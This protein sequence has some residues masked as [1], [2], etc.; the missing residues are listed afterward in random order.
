MLVTAGAFA[1]AAVA[2]CGGC[3]DP[4]PL[5]PGFVVPDAPPAPLARQV[6]CITAPT[7]ERLQAVLRGGE[8]DA[9]G[10][11]RGA[12]V[13][14]RDAT[15]S[16]LWDGFRRDW[17][18]WLL[19]VGWFS[20]REVL[21][22]G[23]RTAA[24]MDPVERARP[25]LFTVRRHGQGLQKVWLGTSLS[26]PFRTVDFGDLDGAGEHELVAL[27]WAP[28]GTPAVRAYT[29][30]GFGIEGVA[31]SPPVPGADD[32]RCGDV[33]GDARAEVVLRFVQAER[34][35]FLALGLSGETLVTVSEL[36]ANVGPQPAQWDLQTVGAV[37]GVVLMR[38]NVRRVLVFPVSG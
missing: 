6:V 7:G 18:P 24:P 4:R 12:A 1:A 23:V 13:A 21:L 5:A 9:T 30:K 8:A 38:G 37:R 17:N 28:D 27:E 26:R 29:W 25:F 3:R 32:L 11:L 14:L 19:R 33:W 2:S 16:T 36:C 35:R 20:G 31:D 15:G 22:V 34:W 10:A